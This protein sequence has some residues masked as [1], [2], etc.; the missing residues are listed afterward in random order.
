[1]MGDAS[2][3]VLITGGTGLLGQALVATADERYRL[4]L[5]H[6]RD[7]L[8]RTKD[9]EQRVLDIVN[10]NKLIDFVSTHHFDV[11]IHAAGLANVDYVET[12]FEEGWQSNVVGTQ[13]VIDLVVKRDM[14]LVYI[15][16]NAVFDGK[17]A[18][19]EEDDLTN[20]INRYGHI[21]VKCEEIVTRMCP[22]AIIIRPILMYGWHVPQGRLNP[23]T[24][25][26]DRLQR[27]EKSHLVTDVYENPLLSYNCAESIWRA[28]QLKKRGTFHIAGK[29]VVNR[30][31]FGR[32]VAELFDL[33]ASLLHPVNSS[34]FPTIAPRP[35]NTSFLT[36]RMQVELGMEPIS[37]SDGLQRMRA[38]ARDS[39]LH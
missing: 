25:I 18:P 21:K 7:Y 15:S 20:P 26:I 28:I 12:H 19:Y 33:D 27:G 24:W 39:G 9:D 32:L 10:Q 34:F 4:T 16:T 31:E 29:E 35:H 30:Y 36:K 2:V 17:C 38:V 37:L 22:E 23:V 6:R 8:V 11:V 5:L 13:N 1:M 3:R 14:R